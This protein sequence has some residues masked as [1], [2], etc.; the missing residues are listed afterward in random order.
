MESP[1]REDFLNLLH[2]K[3]SNLAERK[4]TEPEMS[5][6]LDEF[7]VIRQFYVNIRL[8]YQHGEYKIR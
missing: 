6:I 1:R 8:C 4:F 2:E 7:G 3:A 5:G